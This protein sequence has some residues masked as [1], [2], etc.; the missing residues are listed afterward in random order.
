[1]VGQ[2]GEEDREGAGTQYRDLQ[3]RVGALY[4]GQVVCKPPTLHPPTQPPHTHTQTSCRTFAET[5]WHNIISLTSPSLLRLKITALLF[6]FSNQV[7]CSSF[8][9][10]AYKHVE[11]KG[12]RCWLLKA[13]ILVCLGVMDCTTSRGHQCRFQTF[14]IPH[15]V[16]T[17]VK[18]T[19]AIHLK[20]SL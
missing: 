1:M 20:G 15:S 3:L 16:C 8:F 6:T 5:A 7:K 13:A 9:S 10:S 4:N 19:L 18:P 11:L 12:K 2:K 17:Q 14:T